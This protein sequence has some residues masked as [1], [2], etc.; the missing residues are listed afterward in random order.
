[1]CRPVLWVAVIF[2][3]IAFALT[4]LAQATLVIDTF[5][6]PGVPHTFIGPVGPPTATDSGAGILGTRAYTSSTALSLGDVT[7]IGGGSFS[8]FTGTTALES[9]LGYSFFGTLD[10]SAESAIQYDFLFLDGGTVSTTT[11]F[12]VTLITTTGSLSASITLADSA[13]PFS[14]LLPLSSFTGSGSLTAVTGLVF[15][16]NDAGSPHMGTD[17]VLSSI[18]AVPEASPVVIWSAVSIMGVGFSY[19]RR[20]V[21]LTRRAR[22]LAATAP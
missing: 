14:A 17:Y 8:V 12:D 19:L 2:C 20:H 22:Q 11:E 6:T 7:S 16:F 1:M 4:P 5:D 9:G 13:V 15:A 3:S 21:P 10:F 18:V